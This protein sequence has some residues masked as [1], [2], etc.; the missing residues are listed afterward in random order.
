A[1]LF[2][3]VHEGSDGVDGWVSLEVSPLLADDAAATVA[4]AITLHQ[5]ADRANLFIKIP[6]TPAGLQAIGECIFAGVPVN[7]TLLFSAAQY[8]AAAGAYMTGLERRLAEGLSPDVASVA[9]LF[10]SRWDKALATQGPEALRDRVGIA[11]GAQAY[12]SY[13]ELLASDRWQRLANAGARPQRLLFASTST[14]N[15]AAPDTLYISGLAAPMT[16]NTMPE[17]TLL[18]FADHGHVAGTL[19][20]AGGDADL[21]MS[22]LAAAGMDPAELALRLQR[23]GAAAFEASWNNL[24]ACIGDRAGQLVAGR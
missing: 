12:R 7:V 14:K 2:G 15:P 21:V 23:E 6:G 3:P 5:R 24:V 18:A 4:A 1:D 10:V 20:P 13:H 11:A 22:Q 19:D 9:S 8:V 16:I 17:D